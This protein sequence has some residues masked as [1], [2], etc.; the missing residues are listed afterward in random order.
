MPTAKM[1]FIERYESISQSMRAFSLQLKPYCALS[2]TVSG[3]AT[4]KFPTQLKH[5]S[6]HGQVEPNTPPEMH[7]EVWWLQH[8]HGVH[9]YLMIGWLI[10]LMITQ[11]VQTASPMFSRVN[12]LG[13]FKNC[14]W[15]SLSLFSIWILHMHTLG[16]L[17]TR[18]LW[19]IINSTLLRT[20]CWTAIS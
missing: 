8:L 18:I 14:F 2:L 16:A 19:Q 17:H 13:M 11:Q 7:V 1:K 3:S 20:S 12:L 10:C 6:N 9:F 4:C 5:T 15:R